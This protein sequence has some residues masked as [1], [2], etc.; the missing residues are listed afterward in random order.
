MEPLRKQDFLFDVIVKME[1]PFGKNR[2]AD[3]YMNAE[4]LAKIWDQGLIVSCQSFEGEPIHG[5]GIMVKMAESALWAGAVGLRAN[6][7]QNVK[8]MKEAT[9]L[10]V[11]GIFKQVHKGSDVYITPIMDAVD[12]LVAVGSDVIAVDAT[13]R[14]GPTQEK[15]VELIVAIKAK[16]PDQLIMADVST[17]EE[18]ILAMKKGADFVGTTLSGYTPYSAQIDGPNL[19]LIGQLAKLF[20]K[21]VI[22]EGKVYTTQEARA[23]LDVGALC[24]VVGGAITRPHLTA[25]R[26]VEALEKEG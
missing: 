8:D 12:Q 20:P 22:A 10:P 25:K 1:S 9:S 26:F 11:I 18:G 23:C 6:E 19:E 17:L 5:P 7:P 13:D 2:K 3:E 24:V 14:L 16:Y 4:A 21:R 15:A